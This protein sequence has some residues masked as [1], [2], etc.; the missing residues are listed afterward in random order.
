[1]SRRISTAYSVS[2]YVC[3]FMSKMLPFAC[4]RVIYLDG[5]TVVCGSLQQ[6]WETD[7][8]PYSIAGVMDTVLPE[9]K[10][11]VETSK[12]INSGVLLIDL[13]K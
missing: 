6:L 12:D 3:L 11:T 8:G 5:D 10:V 4:E 13:K 1:M 2:A 9:F 7:L